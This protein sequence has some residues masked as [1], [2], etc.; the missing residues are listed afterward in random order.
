M[1]VAVLFSGAKDS[2]FAIY[3]AMLRGMNIRYLVTLIPR[4]ASETS[5]LHFPNIGWTRLQAKAMGME[6]ITKETTRENELADLVEVLQPIKPDIEGV[7]TGVLENSFQKAKF[8]SVCRKLGLKPVA[9]HWQ[10]SMRDYLQDM[11]VSGFESIVTAVTAEGLDEEW[12]GRKVDMGLVRDLE[13]V[14]VKFGI[15][16]GGEGGEYETFVLDGPIFEKRIEI[17]E[18]RKEWD[19]AK[20]AYVIE[21]ARLVEK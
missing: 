3:K 13:K 21:R 6:L 4:K 10:R 15:H 17:L 8:D 2:T 5:I 20:G 19:G 11:I 9:P 18:A 12:L 16:K 14:S 7:V 1:D